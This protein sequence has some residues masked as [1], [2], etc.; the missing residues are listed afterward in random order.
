MI[1]HYQFGRS[2]FH[3]R[4]I[5]DLHQEVINRD[6]SR[7]VV[8]RKSIEQGQDLVVVEDLG[9]GIADPCARG[10]DHEGDEDIIGDPDLEGISRDQEVVGHGQGD[11]DRGQ[12]AEVVGRARDR[13]VYIED[14]VD[15]GEDQ[16][17]DQGHADIEGEA[18]EDD[19]TVHDRD[20]VDILN[21]ILLGK[22]P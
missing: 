8:D 20:L 5:I 17:V 4:V 7:D 6:R 12:D 16:G 9:Q 22:R 11:E 19:G 21:T 1:R 15:E 3:H 2:R 18:K 13:G 14:D 10:L